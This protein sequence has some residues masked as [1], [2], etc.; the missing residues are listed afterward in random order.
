MIALVHCVPV[1]SSKTWL[2]DVNHPLFWVGALLCRNLVLIHVMIALVIG[3]VCC[4]KTWLED[5]NLPLFWV[6]ALR[7]RNL[8]LNAL[9]NCSSDQSVSATGCSFLSFAAGIG[10]GAFHILYKVII[11]WP[12]WQELAKAPTKICYFLELLG[13]NHGHFFCSNFVVSM[14]AIRNQNDTMRT[15][16]NKFHKVRIDV[17]KPRLFLKLSKR[18]GFNFQL[19]LLSNQYFEHAPLI[20]SSVTM[21]LQLTFQCLHAGWHG[22]GCTLES[23]KGW[24]NYEC[25]FTLHCTANTFTITENRYCTLN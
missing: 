20:V 11:F 10:F 4:S 5:V 6:G 1:C 24:R 18:A 8:V 13:I 21:L 16:R 3:P 15:L 7:C 19:Q 2:K 25:G 17:H 14:F 23:S 12:R 22:R 9:S